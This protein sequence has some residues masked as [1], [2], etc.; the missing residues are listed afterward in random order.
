MWTRRYRSRFCSGGGLPK[1]QT[2]FPV[3]IAYLSLATQDSVLPYEQLCNRCR[4]P[5]LNQLLK[6]IGTAMSLTK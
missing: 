1:R 3:I 5:T 6:T 2:L 4:R